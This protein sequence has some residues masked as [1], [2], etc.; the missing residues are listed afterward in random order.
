MEYVT[1]ETREDRLYLKA[2]G[3]RYETQVGRWLPIMQ[4]LALRGYVPAM[5]EMADWCAGEDDAAPFGAPSDATSPAGYYRRAY[6]K[7]DPVAANNAAISCFNRNDMVGYRGWLR[8]A[9]NAGDLDAGRQLRCFEIRLSHAA[10]GKVRRLRPE[11]KRD[12]WD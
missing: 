5:R 1:D 3:I 4:H 9:A 11:Q 10:A 8:R 7:G 12:G 2:L 6:K